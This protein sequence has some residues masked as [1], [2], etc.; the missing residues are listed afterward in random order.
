MGGSIS[1][2][3]ILEGSESRREDVEVEL[4]SGT[5]LR[6]CRRHPWHSRESAPELDDERKV[7]VENLRAFAQRMA[8][9]APSNSR[10]SPSPSLGVG[11]ARAVSE[12]KVQ[13]EPS[14][15]LEEPAEDNESEA[16]SRRGSPSPELSVESEREES[17]EIVLKSRMPSVRS[18]LDVPRAL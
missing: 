4:I 15:L 2:A 14:P 7:P 5:R 18:T 12:E 10:Q 3:E 9:P 6:P 17:V 8:T 1:C 13:V 16:S 11:V